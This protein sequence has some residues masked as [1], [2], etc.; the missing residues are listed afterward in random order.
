VRLNPSVGVPIVTRGVDDFLS[1]DA[2]PLYAK[3]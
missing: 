2:C 1:H 3:P